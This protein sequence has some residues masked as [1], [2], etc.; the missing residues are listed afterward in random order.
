LFLLSLGMKGGAVFLVLAVG[1]MLISRDT[2]AMTQEEI[3]EKAKNMIKMNVGD[4][5]EL[6][7]EVPYEEVAHY[8]EGQED[9]WEENVYDDEEPVDDDYDE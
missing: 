5:M 8:F 1:C 2:L 6:G 4:G 3:H 7:E 9:E